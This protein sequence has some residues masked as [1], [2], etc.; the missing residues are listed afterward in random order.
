LKRSR[1]EL[2]GETPRQVRH[3]RPRLSK[4]AD[5]DRVYRRGRSVASRHLVL[6]AF[7]WG[8]EAGSRDADQDETEARLGVSV[9]RKVGG[10]VDRNRVK[11][12]IREAFWSLPDSLPQAHDYVVVARPG[13]ASLLEAEGLGALRGDLANLVARFGEEQDGLS[14]GAPS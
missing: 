4:S 9:G 2:P 8:D 5:F 11:R 10:A 3:R 6:Y 7:P 14:G 13:A 1:P 12:C